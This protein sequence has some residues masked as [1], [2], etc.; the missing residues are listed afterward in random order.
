MVA[1]PMTQSFVQGSCTSSNQTLTPGATWLTYDGTH[2]WAT[3]G[4]GGDFDQSVSIPMNALPA[5]GAWDYFDLTSIWN[6]PAYATQK[7]E[8]Q[9][10]GVE[11]TVSPEDPT[12]VLPSTSYVTESF[13]NDNATPPPT[14][15]VPCL[16]VTFA[17]VPEPSTLALLVA[18]AGL[19]AIGFGRRC[20]AGRRGRCWQ[21]PW[22]NRDVS[23]PGGQGCPPRMPARG[24]RMLKCRRPACKGAM[25]AWPGDGYN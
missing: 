1:Y 9:N 5:T 14:P 25:R 4:G 2:P 23:K 15:I 24:E 19:A 3:P 20:R 13:R 6:N 10:Y 22:N 7:Q 8:M 12:Q 21:D 17:P 11:L 18:G 16:A